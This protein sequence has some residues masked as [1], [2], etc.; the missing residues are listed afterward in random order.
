MQQYHSIPSTPVVA[1]ITDAELADWLGVDVSDPLLPVMA[2][3]AT[4]AVIDFLEYELLTRERVTHWENWP[5][6][7]TLSGPSLSPP[8]AGLMA[9]IEL[10]YAMPRGLAV[11]EVLVAGEAT[12]DYRIT[13]R[14]TAS[15]CFDAFPVTTSDTEA[16]KITY[17]SGF[18]PNASDTPLAIRTATFMTADFLYNNRGSCSASDAL[19]KSGA[20]AVLT[21]YKA[22]VVIL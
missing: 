12:T 1:V 13:V 15:I 9:E 5:T 22:K 10:P 18:G 20:G 7:G 4:A 14:R 21:P 16:L 2:E 6:L 19:G 8:D 17:T 11:T 3:T